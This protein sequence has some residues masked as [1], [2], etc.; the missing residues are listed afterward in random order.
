VRVV[1]VDAV[2]M[3]VMLIG[4]YRF[5]KKSSKLL[6]KRERTLLWKNSMEKNGD[7]I[8]VKAHEECY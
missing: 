4:Q 5:G 1:R 2:F 3:V 7:V 6:W 8:V